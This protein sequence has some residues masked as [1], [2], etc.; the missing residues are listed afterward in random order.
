M[1]GSVIRLM[2]GK[3]IAASG[4]LIPGLLGRSTFIVRVRVKNI[5]YHR[6]IPFDLWV[7]PVDED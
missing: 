4:S 3:D 1:T 2:F 5:N 7:V 6:T